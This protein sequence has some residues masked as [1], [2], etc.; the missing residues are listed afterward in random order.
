[1]NGETGNLVTRLINLFFLFTNVAFC[2]VAIW[3]S[4]L[5]RTTHVYAVS[6]GRKMTID[7]YMPKGMSG[8]VPVLALTHGGGWAVGSKRLIEPA[9]LAQ[10]KRGYGLASIQYTLSAKA[11]WP[12]Q[13]HEVKAAYRWLRANAERLGLN[14]E[15]IIGA[16]ISAGGHLAL[17]AG[18]S[19]PDTLEGDLGDHADTSSAVSG[20]VTFYPPTSLEGIAEMGRLGRRTVSKFMGKSDPDTRATRLAEATPATYA[21]QDAPPVFIMHGNR[22]HVVPYRQATELTAALEA[23]GADVTFLTLDKRAHADWWFNA[24]RHRPAFNAFVDRASDLQP[25]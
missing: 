9:F 4:G 14:P 24:K 22:D 15:R 3:A 2:R 17:V 18:L 5:K 19:G 16:G 6:D 10:V 23:V 8:P 1:M 25:K 21:R 7:L 20:I 12:A 13:I 11:H